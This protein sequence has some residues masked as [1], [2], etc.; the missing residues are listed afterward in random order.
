MILPPDDKHGVPFYVDPADQP[1]LHRDTFKAWG[2]MLLGE[3]HLQE[4][5]L[6]EA[7]KTLLPKEYLSD[8]EVS[9]EEDGR[10]R[11]S[12]MVDSSDEEGAHRPPVMDS[13]DEE[14]AHR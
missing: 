13:S 8:S 11:S 1:G 6:T 10:S 12:V 7:I 9:E 14:G 3:L 4:F 5:S 2:C